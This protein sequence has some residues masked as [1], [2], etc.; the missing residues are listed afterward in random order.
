MRV[1]TAGVMFYLFFSIACSGGHQNSIESRADNGSTT[2]TTDYFPQKNSRIIRKEGWK[3]LDTKGLNVTGKEVIVMK[4]EAGKLIKANTTYFRPNHDAYYYNV[5]GF[6]ENTTQ[7]FG[8]IKLWGVNEF[9]ISGKIFMYAVHAGKVIGDTASN[10]GLDSN[11]LTVAYYQ[12]IILDS[13][14]DGVFET[15]IDDTTDPSDVPVP[16]WVAK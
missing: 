5:E 2:P 12:Y 1:V 11:S 15:L 14:G 10:T 7:L 9:K 13:D 6:S 16:K 4:T 8:L 3:V